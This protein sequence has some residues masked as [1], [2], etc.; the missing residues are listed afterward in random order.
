MANSGPSSSA[1]EDTSL[2]TTT[3]DLMKL[4]TLSNVAIELRVFEIIHNLI[5]NGVSSDAVYAFLVTA[6]KESKLGKKLLKARAKAKDISTTAQQ[7]HSQGCQ[8]NQTPRLPSS[9][10]NE[11][12]KSVLIESNQAPDQV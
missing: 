8:G 5:R 7:Q 9:S 10:S 12:R 1:S 11:K 3:S 2:T 6:M 4:Y